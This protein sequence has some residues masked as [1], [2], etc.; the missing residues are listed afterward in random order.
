MAI[1]MKAKDVNALDGCCVFFDYCALQHALK[2]YQNQ[3]YISN[4]YGW[5]CSV[6]L[7]IGN[8]GINLITGYS[9]GRIKCVDLPV[10]LKQKFEKIERSFEK[11]RI[12]DYKDYKVYKAA[13]LRRMRKFEK[14]L[15]ETKS[16]IS[17]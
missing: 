16:Y 9:N 14:L 2:P 5:A 12:G 15:A 6:Y 11:C 8:S 1:Q 4:S 13:V 7:N 10:D 17:A 3:G